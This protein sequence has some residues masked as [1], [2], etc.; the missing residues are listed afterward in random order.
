MLVVAD[1]DGEG[2]VYQVERQEAGLITI[3]TCTAQESVSHNHCQVFKNLDLSALD[4]FK[5]NYLAGKFYLGA[6]KVPS[7]IEMTES[8]FALAFKD[9]SLG[10]YYNLG[11]SPE[12]LLAVPGSQTPAVA[13]F[14]LVET[15]LTEAHLL[16]RGDSA[17]IKV[18]V[19]LKDDGASWASEE[20]RLMETGDADISALFYDSDR[21]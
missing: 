21:S 2:M 18:T 3:V 16:Y 15:S 6:N 19:L 9:G 12:F 5:R 8:F 10:L 7:R 4:D 14:T 17:L 13:V 1:L 11:Q 20:T